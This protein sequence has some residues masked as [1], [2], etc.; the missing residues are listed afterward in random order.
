MWKSEK[1]LTF[2]GKGLVC[3]D[4]SVHV[5][6]TSARNNT[7]TQCCKHN[8]PRLRLHPLGVSPIPV[9]PDGPQ[10]ETF[11]VLRWTVG[12]FVVVCLAFKFKDLDIDKKSV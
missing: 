3:Q 9:W 7:H 6:P 1:Y 5:K 4:K 10:Y 8:V 12:L 2:G 11:L